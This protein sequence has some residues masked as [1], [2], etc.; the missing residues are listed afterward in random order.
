[1]VWYK[2]VVW[3]NFCVLLQ[4]IGHARIGHQL[5]RIVS[6]TGRMQYV[7]VKGSQAG[8]QSLILE[9]FFTVIAAADDDG[10]LE[11]ARLFKD[12]EETLE[13]FIG[14]GKGLVVWLS[15]SRRSLL[16]HVRIVLVEVIELSIKGSG[17]ILIRELTQPVLEQRQHP[18][19]VG[20]SLVV[21][22]QFLRERIDHFI[23]IPDQHIVQDFP[24]AC[25]HGLV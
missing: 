13:E 14:G 19:I 24:L 2:S 18:S 6:V 10:V 16:F 20:P 7:R 1:M 12:F 21:H 22:G 15:G 23:H 5:F 8:P 25:G 17:F 9:R 4:P 3:I 11:T